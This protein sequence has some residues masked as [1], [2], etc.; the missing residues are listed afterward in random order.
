MMITSIVDTDGGNFKTGLNHAFVIQLASA[1]RLS[2]LR[3]P[4]VFSRFGPPLQSSTTETRSKI[5]I[6]VSL[7]QMCIAVVAQVH[8]MIL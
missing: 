6:A 8:L 1:A 7:Q 2:Y 4:V 3:L 5:Y